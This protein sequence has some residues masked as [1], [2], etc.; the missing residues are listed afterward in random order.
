MA[1]TRLTYDSTVDLTQ[2]Q[3]SEELSAIE[4][5]EL[6]LMYT[7][8]NE[9]GIAEFDLTDKVT[10]ETFNVGFSLRSWQGYQ[11]N[12]G[13]HNQKSGVYIF[14]PYQNQYDS[15]LYSEVSNVK[16]SKCGA[17]DQYVVTFTAS[18]YYEGDA[19]VTITIEEDLAVLKYE[20][21]LY[22]LKS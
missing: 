3:E 17:K 11:L 12:D 21:E 22:G 5:D 16:V 19:A 20:V 15:D 13:M 8:S 1:F 9:Q 6:S 10:G 4:T 18:G 14:R 2:C 7:G